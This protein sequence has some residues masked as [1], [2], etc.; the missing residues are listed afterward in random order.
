MKG[1]CALC[2]NTRNLERS[3]VIP[4]AAFKKIKRSMSGKAIVSDDE[5][6][7][8]Q[9]SSESWWEYML[10]GDCEDRFSDYEKYFTEVLRGSRRAKHKINKYGM[11][12]VDLDHRVSKLFL[13]SLLWRAAVSRQT[14]FQKV[15][16]HPTWAEE[17]RQSLYAE[18]PLSQ[19]KYGCKILKLNDPTLGGFSMENL[20]QIVISPIPRVTGQRM[21]FLFLLEGYL[22]EFFCPSVPFSRSKERGVYRNKKVFFVPFQA[23]C[24]SRR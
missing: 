24:Q 1:E 22:F 4:N 21:S 17:F 7:W 23:I 19:L 14:K 20:D 2:K 8:V 9:Y 6:S 5:H 13:Q 12:F 3:H 15:V 16:L 11:T 10:C 18:K